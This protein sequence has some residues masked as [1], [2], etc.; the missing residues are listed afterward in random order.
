MCGGAALTVLLLHERVLASP[1][2]A[3]ARLSFFLLSGTFVT[4]GHEGV[5]R[6]H[7]VAH[8]SHFYIPDTWKYPLGYR[9][10]LHGLIYSIIG[11]FVYYRYAQRRVAIMDD[12]FDQIDSAEYQARRKENYLKWKNSARGQAFLADLKEQRPES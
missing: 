6:M 1:V 4:M 9:V 10:V 12:F 2:H 11:S 8:Q 5:S 3:T 7:H